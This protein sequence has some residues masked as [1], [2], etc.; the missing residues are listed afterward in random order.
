MISYD[1]LPREIEEFPVDKL[2]DLYNIFFRMQEVCE[3]EKGVGIAAPQL[4]LPYNL[5]ICMDNTSLK[6]NYYVNSKIIYY[7]PESGQSL[8]GCLSIR[9]PEGRLRHFQVE[10]SNFIYVKC[11]KLIVDGKLELE[12]IDN[13]KLEGLDSIVFQH[14]MDHCLGLS[15]LDKGKEFFVY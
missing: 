9:S 5:F 13:L 11:S 6:Y 1:K 7:S 12:E 3:R 10:R 14:E 2:S 4:G 15:I 8:E